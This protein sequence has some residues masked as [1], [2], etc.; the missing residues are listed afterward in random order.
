MI[1]L[2]GL[3]GC[4]KSTIGRRLATTLGWKSIDI[5]R[6]IEAKLGCSIAAF[7]EQ[8]G[9]E[10]FRDVEQ[11]VLDR[12]T[13]DL[14]AVIATGG[15]AVLR[16][17]NRTVLKERA[18]VV[19]LI[20]P[21]PEL[22]KRLARDKRRPL[23]RGPGELDA[24]LSDLFEVRDPLYRATAHVVVSAAGMTTTLAT[25]AVVAALKASF[26][27]PSQEHKPVAAPART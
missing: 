13:R 9:E 7:F 4:G 16:Q 11:D 8:R 5:D 25:T 20:S 18:T 12:A 21:L 14:G 19:Y 27:W 3:P 1:A 15:G 2:V 24:K 6:D 10:A 23:L 26:R 17:A 22:A